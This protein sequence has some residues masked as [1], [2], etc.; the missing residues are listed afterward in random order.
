[1]T[2]RTLSA[3]VIY[4]NPFCIPTKLLNELRTMQHCNTHSLHKVTTIW[5]RTNRWF[6]KSRSVS[7]SDHILHIY[8]VTFPG[9]VSFYPPFLTGGQVAVAARATFRTEWRI[10]LN[11]VHSTCLQPSAYLK[12]VTRQMFKIPSAKYWLLVLNPATNNNKS[13]RAML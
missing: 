2:N 3:L 6:Y 11:H 9:T 4:L 12:L 7:F 5:G 13:R 8:T 10:T 1:M